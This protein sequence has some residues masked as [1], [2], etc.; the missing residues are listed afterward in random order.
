[1]KLSIAQFP[2]NDLTFYKTSNGMDV[3]TPLRVMCPTTGKPTTI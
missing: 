1:V 3:L 2:R